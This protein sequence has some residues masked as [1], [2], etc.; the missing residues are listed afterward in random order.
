MKNKYIIKPVKASSTSDDPNIVMTISLLSAINSDGFRISI[1]DE[2]NA[3]TLFEKEYRYGYD[4]SYSKSFANSKKPYVTDLIDR[5]VDFY[6]VDDIQVIAGKNRFN[7]KSI[8]NSDIQNFKNKY[9]KASSN[10][11]ASD[12]DDEWTPYP[13]TYKVSGGYS[14]DYVGDYDEELA[15][16][17][18]KG[19]TERNFDDPGKA[20]EAWF[21][22]EQKHR[23]DVAIMCEK[24]DDAVR[25]LDWCDRNRDFIEDWHS[26]YN[27]PYKLEWI[28]DGIDKNLDNGCKYFYEDK[29][30]YGDQISP[31]SYG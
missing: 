30:G 13:K 7:D 10:V 25:L 29:Y 9:L 28:L 16:Y 1:D 22:L 31:F 15:E 26:K 21:K 23:G 8:S 17:V 11:L 5:L 24:R 2:S 18:S 20:V 3:D 19:S 12:D 6:N 14:G 27:C 4:V